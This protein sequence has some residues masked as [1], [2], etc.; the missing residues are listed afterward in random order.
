MEF[1]QSRLGPLPLGGDLAIGHCGRVLKLIVVALSACLLASCGVEAANVSGVRVSTRP[2][3]ALPPPPP[4]IM[5][6]LSDKPFPAANVKL[7]VGKQFM[8]MFINQSSRTQTVTA[9]LPM[10]QLEILNPA[11]TNSPQIESAEQEF[12]VTI[13]AGSEADVILAPAKEGSFAIK[14]DSGPMGNLIAS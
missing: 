9:A 8:F 12:S 3:A 5:A 13:A 2:I 7:N 11:G 1:R 4:M 6:H 14:S 10:T